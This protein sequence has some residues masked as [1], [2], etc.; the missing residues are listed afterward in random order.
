[1]MIRSGEHP[2][3][4]RAVG[5]EEEARGRPHRYLYPLPIAPG[6]SSRA[7]R[8]PVAVTANAH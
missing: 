3:A 4:D 8:L 1:M 7:C 6:D 2:A 5:E